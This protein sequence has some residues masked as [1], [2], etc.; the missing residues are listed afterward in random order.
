MLNSVHFYHFTGAITDSSAQMQFNH[1]EMTFYLYRDFYVALPPMFNE[2]EPGQKQLKGKYLVSYVNWE[3]KLGKKVNWEEIYLLGRQ[4]MKTFNHSWIFFP[5]ETKTH[6]WSR[7]LG[8]DA[9][10]E[11]LPV[12]TALTSLPCLATS[13]FLGCH[14]RLAGQPQVYIYSCWKQCGRTFLKRKSPPKCTQPH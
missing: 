5:C 13:N 11:A 3:A 10:C 4:T 2:W 8:T 14:M 1:L 6:L 7:I 12:S 9:I